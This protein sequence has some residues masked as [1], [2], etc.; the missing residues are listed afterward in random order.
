MEKPDKFFLCKGMREVSPPFF[1]G[2]LRRLNI[3]QA[4]HVQKTNE[5]V[6]HIDPRPAG[7]VGFRPPLTA[8]A[9]NISCVSAVA[10]GSFAW[11]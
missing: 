3:G 8:P 5:A 6:Y 7:V 9:I 4:P 11:Q 1:P 2:N 10:H